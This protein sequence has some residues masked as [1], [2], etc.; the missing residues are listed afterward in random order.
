MTA[1]G[2]VSFPGELRR[3]ATSAGV[4]DGDRAR[5][6]AI[7]AHLERLEAVEGRVLELLRSVVHSDSVA[8]IDGALEE[9]LAWSL[10]RG[11]LRHG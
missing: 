8:A 3:L 6:L 10:G 2:S 4:P 11:S 5:L 1:R 9:L 7:A